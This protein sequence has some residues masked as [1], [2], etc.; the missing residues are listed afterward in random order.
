MLK[1]TNSIC[2]RGKLVQIVLT[3]LIICID[4]VLVPLLHQ[5]YQRQG[6][7]H[8]RFASKHFALL[9]IFLSTFYS[10]YILRRWLQMTRQMNSSTTSSLASEE[11]GTVAILGSKR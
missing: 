4:V 7:I 3:F 5:T 2:I 11:A 10:S 1:V 6:K 8:S 9:C